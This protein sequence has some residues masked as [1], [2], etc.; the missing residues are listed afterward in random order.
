MHEHHGAGVA[1]LLGTLPAMFGPVSLFVALFLA[2]I[3]AGASHCIGMC[4]PFVVS[5]AIRA[6][7]RAA[8]ADASG[9]ARL[10]AG[11][12]P[13]YHLG[14]AI[15]YS[16]FGAL[17]GAVGSGFAS[18]VEMGWIRYVFV[19]S[20]AVL[21]LL[22]VLAVARPAASAGGGPVGRLV[23]R[24][25]GALARAPGPLGDLGLGLALG[26]L[27]CG[28][29]YAALAAAAGAGGAVEGALTMASFA[30]GTWPGLFVVGA[31]GAASGRHWRDAIRR[32]A[33]P[34]AVLNLGA[35]ALWV[36]GGH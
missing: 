31:L 30:A 28:M 7:A 24:T 21:F 20:A 22:P 36:A 10:R 16:A 35:L 1:E 29:V 13:A 8:V 2:G 18:V 19:G 4:G 6:G 17:T 5:R 12:L 27:P 25:A 14:R 32:L 11:A 33:L 9:L 26:F 34:I 15:T 23:A 3:V